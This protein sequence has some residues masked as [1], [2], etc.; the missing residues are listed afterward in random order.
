M[1][2]E[3]SG[4]GDVAFR[5][6]ESRGFKGNYI[7]VRYTDFFEPQPHLVRRDRIEVPVPKKPTM[8]T[9]KGVIPIKKS[10]EQKQKPLAPAPVVKKP[11][12]AP[13]VRKSSAPAAGIQEASKQQ[14]VAAVAGKRTIDAELAKQTE[15]EFRITPSVGM[16]LRCALPK[17]QLDGTL[18]FLGYIPNLPKRNHLLVAGLEIDGPEDLATDGTF[19][20]KRYFET[21][22]KRAYFL[23]F[24]SCKQA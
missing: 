19:F 3:S 18:Q 10:T 17:K 2:D 4:S 8:Q 23:P 14:T 13:M 7:P 20:G 15:K 24:R 9:R 11:T 6:A 16:K 5:L 22:P 1:S 21:P 12:P